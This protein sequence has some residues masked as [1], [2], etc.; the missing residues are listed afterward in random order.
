MLGPEK[1]LHNPAPAL[2]LCWLGSTRVKQIYR[3]WVPPLLRGRIHPSWRHDHSH[4][5]LSITSHDYQLLWP[6]RQPLDAVRPWAP[7]A[8]AEVRDEAPQWPAWVEE[9]L[10]KTEVQQR[11]QRRDLGL[12]FSGYS[13]HALDRIFCGIILSLNFPSIYQW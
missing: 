1:G 7:D 8:L 4:K 9:R 2:E 10:N 5:K 3:Y 13:G 6:I 12:S 11:K